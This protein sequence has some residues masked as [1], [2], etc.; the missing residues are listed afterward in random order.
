MNSANQEL[1]KLH[2][3][4]IGATISIFYLRVLNTMTNNTFHIIDIFREDALKG[5][6][7]HKN[8]FTRATRLEIFGMKNDAS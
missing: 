8:H 5:K 6:D 1:Y 2:V 4:E 7:K 3:D